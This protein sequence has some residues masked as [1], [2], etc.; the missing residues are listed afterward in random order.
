MVM[1]GVLATVA[2]VVRCAGLATHRTRNLRSGARDGFRPHP[3]PRRA[4]AR[5]PP[6]RPRRAPASWILGEKKKA[7]LKARPERGLGTSL[8]VESKGRAH[9][10]HEVDYG[11]NL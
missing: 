6:S 11:E 10:I 1:P 8:E 3:P 5:Y 7:P 9:L 2:W 4:I